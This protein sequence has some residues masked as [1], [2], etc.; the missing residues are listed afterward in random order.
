VIFAGQA[1][2]FTT[3][4]QQINLQIPDSAPAGAMQLML[5]AGP[6]ETQTGVTL[7]IAPASAHLRT[8]ARLR[9]QR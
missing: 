5:T 7:Q 3:G 9:G 2:S 6:T 1:P 4:L 8:E